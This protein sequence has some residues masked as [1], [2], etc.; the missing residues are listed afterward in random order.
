MDPGPSKEGEDGPARI[1]AQT[2]NLRKKPGKNEKKYRRRAEA[3]KNFSRPQAKPPAPKFFFPYWGQ[4][5]RRE[6]I[7]RNRPGK[8]LQLS[9]SGGGK[10]FKKKRSPQ[11]IRRSVIWVAEKRGRG[12]AGRIAALSEAASTHHD[13]Q[14]KN[15]SSQQLKKGP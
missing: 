7:P 10:L 13:P 8:Q 9:S 2:K 1:A 14:K 6:F 15:V 5:G 3:A 4:V 12:P 11:T